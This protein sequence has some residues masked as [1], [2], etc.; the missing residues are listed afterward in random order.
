MHAVD[1]PG[2]RGLATP[3]EDKSGSSSPSVGKVR[4]LALQLESVLKEKEFIQENDALIE[5]ITKEIA[6][7]SDAGEV[8]STNMLKS[9][10]ALELMPVN[11][12]TPPLSPKLFEKTHPKQE[13]GPEPPPKDMIEPHAKP[14]PL[15]PRR[16]LPPIPSVT[17]PSLAVSE[18]QK[19]TPMGSHTMRSSSLPPK[20]PPPPPNAR[21][22]T[23][24]SWSRSADPFFRYV[25]NT[26]SKID[27]FGFV[28]G[29]Q[30]E[31]GRSL[32]KI[33]ESENAKAAKWRAM[34]TEA[35]VS[36]A[37][38]EMALFGKAFGV[39]GLVSV[40]SEATVPLKVAV[41]P[42]FS[43][44]R[45]TK[46]PILRLVFKGDTGDRSGKVAA[47]LCK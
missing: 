24:V 42:I 16:K 10:T 36:A 43:F 44:T 19:I 12:S 3:P 15:P 23:P 6:D 5:S 2:L 13:A 46:R 32:A 30:A 29:D 45:D 40:A 1:S 7:K 39:N 28:S 20:A 27:R 38:R 18:S 37:V 31:M 35:D 47:I 4:S 14:P 41:A 21:E 26:Y 34:A 9:S 22:I 33:L 8:F 17:S 25:E 11:A